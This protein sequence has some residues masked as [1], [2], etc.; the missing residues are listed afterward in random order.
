MSDCTCPSE[1]FYEDADTAG[2]AIGIWP[3]PCGTEWLPRITAVARGER[4]LRIQFSC[5][6]CASRFSR[7]YDCDEE[8]Y[9]KPPTWPTQIRSGRLL[10]F[11][12]DS[13][14]SEQERFLKHNRSNPDV[15]WADRAQ[16][17]K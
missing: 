1:D 6:M 5:E 9:V 12:R 11:F 15:L 17:P 4:F 3:C 14:L 2:L 13:D 16:G 7:I 10:D 8:G